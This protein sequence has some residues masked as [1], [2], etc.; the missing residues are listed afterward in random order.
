MFIALFSNFEPGCPLLALFD[1]IDV[2]RTLCT[3]S[4]IKSSRT[5]L[6]LPTTSIR[7]MYL[8]TY[9]HCTTYTVQRAVDI[10]LVY[11]HTYLSIYDNISSISRQK[12][13]E[14]T[15][16]VFILYYELNGSSW[17]SSTIHTQVE[18]P[19]TSKGSSWHR[20]IQC[21]SPR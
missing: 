21:G 7:Y 1:N 3:H 6:Y 9:M 10:I 15:F 4:P 16:V 8:S 20:S 11:V 17:S 12:Q 14:S 2:M 5:R 13:Y 19:N 18:V